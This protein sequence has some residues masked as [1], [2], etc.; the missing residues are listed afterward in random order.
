MLCIAYCFIDGIVTYMKKQAGDSAKVLED[1]AAI[2][3]FIDNV[4]HSIIGEFC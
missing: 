2:E 3:K 4:E 1:M